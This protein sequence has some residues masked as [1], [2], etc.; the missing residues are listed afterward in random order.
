MVINATNAAT[1]TTRIV[2]N[3]ETDMPSDLKANNRMKPSKIHKDMVIKKILK[4]SFMSLYMRKVLFTLLKNFIIFFFLPFIKDMKKS[5]D[6]KD[7]TVFKRILSE[8]IIITMNT[9]NIGKNTSTGIS[10]GMI[11][12]IVVQRKKVPI[13][14]IMIMTSMSINLSKRVDEMVVPMLFPSTVF[15]KKDFMGSPTLPGVIWDMKSPA[16]YILKTDQ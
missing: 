11:L 13:E 6:W 9:R 3:K 2:E 5:I 10:Q 4:N 1:A 14:I 16:K 12:L 7:E 15:S 8:L